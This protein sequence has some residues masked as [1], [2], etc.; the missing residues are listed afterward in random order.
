MIEALSRHSK[1]GK[2]ADPTTSTPGAATI[3]TTPTTTT[4]G[5]A[6]ATALRGKS[7]DDKDVS[8][9]LQEWLN[10]DKDRSGSGY[11]AMTVQEQCSSRFCSL[12]VDVEK[13][14]VIENFPI[15]RQTDAAVTEVTTA[16]YQVTYQTGLVIPPDFGRGEFDD[17]ETFIPTTAALERSLSGACLGTPFGCDGSELIAYKPKSN[18]YDEAFADFVRGEGHYPNLVFEVKKQLNDGPLVLS[19]KYH[20]LLNGQYCEVP[21]PYKSRIEGAYKNYK[22]ENLFFFVDLYEP[23]DPLSLVMRLFNPITSLDEALLGDFL[24]EQEVLSQLA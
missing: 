14:Q 22:Y 5:G 9:K 4:R 18:E 23:E 19:T 12:V 8:T 6:A 24:S 15:D 10:L 21:G 16:K 17:D 20:Q 2:S 11:V 13:M 3:P 1:M 7:L